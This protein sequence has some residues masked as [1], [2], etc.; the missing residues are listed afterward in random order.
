RRTT[1]GDTTVIL[2]RVDGEGSPNAKTSHF[3]ILR[4]AA[5]TQD[6]GRVIRS[7]PFDSLRS[8]RAGSDGEGSPNATTSHFAIL[9][10]ASPTQDDGRVIRSRPF[11]SLRS[12]RAGS[13]GEGSQDATAAHFGILRRPIRFA[14]GL[15]R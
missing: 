14:Q 5:P 15:L 2:S 3:E 9:R 6:D 13:D 7:R 4:R 8:L 12:L 1:R 11:D 10:R